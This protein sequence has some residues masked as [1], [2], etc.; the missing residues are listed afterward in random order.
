MKAE[1]KSVAPLCL[2]M[3]VMTENYLWGSFCPIPVVAFVT[4]GL[5][6]VPDAGMFVLSLYKMLHA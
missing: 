5:Q 6:A 1:A 2:S 4:G 3:I